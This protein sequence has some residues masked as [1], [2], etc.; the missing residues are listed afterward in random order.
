MLI[1]PLL[2]GLFALLLVAITWLVIPLGKTYIKQHKVV[3]I[4]GVTLFICASS[5][6]YR[7]WGAMNGLQ[8]LEAFHEIDNFFAEFAKNKNQTKE[9]L[10][11][12]LAT[13]HKNVAYSS[14]ALARLGNIYNELGMYEEAI[15]C[16]NQAHILAPD[17][18]D[19]QVQWIYSTALLKQGKLAPEV[20]LLAE[21]ITT[22]QPRQFGL[23]NILAI[24]AYFR[25]DFAQAASYWQH[26]ISHDNSLS[27]DRKA[28]LEKAIHK[29]T[30]YISPQKSDDIVVK[31]DVTLSK[32]LAALVSPTDVV[33]IYVKAPNIKMPLAVLRREVREL[34]FTVELTNKQQMLPGVAMKAGEKVEI[35][36]KISASGDPLAIRGVLKG[37]TQERVLNSGINSVNIDINQS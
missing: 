9:Q 12:R 6:L 18:I 15:T 14:A 25:S 11:T 20:R 2:L 27:D 34:P 24:D 33:F 5:G 35:I 31:V 26:L 19:Y 30:L 1:I 17:N 22:E 3:I 28:I 37:E 8:H 21:R 7:Y 13:L 10:T 16:F 23:M 29:A 36:A 32:K 4:I